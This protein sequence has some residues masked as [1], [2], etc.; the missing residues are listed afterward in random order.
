MVKMKKRCL[1]LA[2]ITWKTNKEIEDEKLLEGLLP[3]KEEIE[4][5]ELEI[6][7]INLLQDLEVI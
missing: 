4:L 3:T 6:N 2:K 1:K 7:V 5:A